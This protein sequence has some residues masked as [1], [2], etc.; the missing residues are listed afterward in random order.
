[1]GKAGFA[2]LQQGGKRLQI[3]VKKDAVG[4]KGFNLYK[5]PPES[6]RPHRRQRISFFAPAPAELQHVHVEQIEFLSKDLL[7]LPIG[8]T[9]EADASAEGGAENRNALT[10]V[11][12]RYRQR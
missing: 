5:L 11:E 10:D 6:R 3:Y 12:M 1:M 7:P 9:V 2:H 8:K 4:D